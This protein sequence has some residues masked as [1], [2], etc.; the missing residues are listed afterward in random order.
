MF[1]IGPCPSTKCDLACE[2]GYEYSTSTGCAKCQCKPNCI[3]KSVL[4]YC[5]GDVDCG[6]GRLYKGN[7]G[8]KVENSKNVLQQPCDM[9]WEM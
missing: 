9:V 3:S 4:K 7:N 5:I 2:N 6:Y 8:R 1:V